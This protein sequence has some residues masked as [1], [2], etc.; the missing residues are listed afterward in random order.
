MVC[1]IIEKLSGVV[2]G[3]N[4]IFE[5]SHHYVAG[6]VR[7]FVNG[8][9]NEASG[10]DGWKELGTNRISLKEIPRPTDI[11]QAYYIPR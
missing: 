5:T 3:F 2:N 1:P 7:I 6:S 11:L 9:V 4:T 8:N 10:P